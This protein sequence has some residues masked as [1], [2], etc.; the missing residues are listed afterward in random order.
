MAS[1]D[2]NDDLDVSSPDELDNYKKQM[3]LRAAQ[4]SLGDQAIQPDADPEAT[5][6]PR[7]LGVSVFPTLRSSGDLANN[8]A[9][10]AGK[11]YNAVD[12]VGGLA[13]GSD[14]YRSA[15]DMLNP[16]MGAMSA[17]H[18]AALPMVLQRMGGLA[19]DASGAVHA[20]E[21]LADAG[22]AAEDIVPIFSS[23]GQRAGRMVNESQKALS[24]RLSP[25]LQMIA[26]RKK[27]LGM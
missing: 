5:A 4:S 12:T 26:D 21:G 25:V 18:A 24:E 14:Q 9:Q 3:A 27:R 19:E 7:D 22:K 11:A 8:I 13:K 15:L 10:T 16:E 20:A 1:Q 17:M 2:P 6:A 23:A